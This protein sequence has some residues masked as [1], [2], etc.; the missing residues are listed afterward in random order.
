MPGSSDTANPV[1]FRTERE[2]DYGN[3]VGIEVADKRQPPVGR[4]G[5]ALGSGAGVNAA[6]G[7]ARSRVE[8]QD[9][10]R[11]AVGEDIAFGGS[12]CGKDDHAGRSAVVAG[13]RGTRRL[14]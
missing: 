2:V 8:F 14:L 9:R 12:R 6:L 13:S 7:V 11:V 10:R 3:I 1:D 5:D 4:D